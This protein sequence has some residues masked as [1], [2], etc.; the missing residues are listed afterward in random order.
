MNSINLK[1]LS[2]WEAETGESQI[3][4]QPGLHRK[5]LVPPFPSEKTGRKEKNHKSDV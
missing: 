1:S 2:T 5:I 3:L 4:G